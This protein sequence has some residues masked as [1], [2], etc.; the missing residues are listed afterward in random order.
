VDEFA[1]PDRNNNRQVDESL[2]AYLQANTQDNE[3]LMAVSSSMQGAAYVLETGRPVLYMGGFGG[4]DPVVDATDI[5]R[6]VTDGD[7]AFVMLGGGRSGQ[8]GVS[9]WV[10]ANCTAVPQLTTNQTTPPGPNGRNAAS[11]YHCV[12]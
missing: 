8:Q 4:G 11:L 6:M 1:A 2:L 12:R 9:E 3:Y 7:L 5:A 10:Q